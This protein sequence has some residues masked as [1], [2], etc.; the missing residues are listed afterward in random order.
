M[1]TFRANFLLLITAIIWGSAFVAQDNAGEVLGAF[2]I[3]FSRYLVG[4]IVLIPL[5]L[6]INF[7]EGNNNPKKKKGKLRTSF[8]GGIFCGCALFVA[9][10]LQQFGINA[11]ADPGKAGF[12]T[13]MYIVIVPLFGLFLKKK[14]GLFCWIAVAIAPFGL[15]FLCMDGFVMPAASDL[16]LLACAVVFSVHILVIDKFS[17]NA[18]GVLMSSIQFLTVAVLS[19]ICMIVFEQEYIPE[20]PK[21][22]KDIAYLGIMSSGVAYTLQIIGQKNTSPTVA[23][24]IMSLESVFAMVFGA[25][26]VMEM[27]SGRKILGATIIFAA[28]ILAQLPSPQI[29]RSK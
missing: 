19:F 21:A 22:S 5:F 11:G 23:S 12:I 16:I 1:K 26:V 25:L 3:N 20:I 6:Y 7:K 17:P 9:S 8:I 18:N 14:V 4:G 15:Y 10:A 24:L 28:V 13:V 2:S 27:P 29:K